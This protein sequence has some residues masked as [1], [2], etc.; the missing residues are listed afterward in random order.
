MSDDDRKFL[1]R[2]RSTFAET[3]FRPYVM[4]IGQTALAWNDLHEW[5][6]RLF[7]PFVKGPDRMNGFAIWQSQ[8]VDRSKRE[9]LRA[10]ASAATEQF[11][12]AWPRLIPDILWICKETEALEDTRNN[13]VHAPLQ[14]LLDVAKIPDEKSQRAF[15]A[16]SEVAPFDMGENFRAKRLVAKD[17]LLEFR[18]CRD[19]LLAL[20]N[21]TASVDTAW[22]KTLPWPDRPTLPTREDTRKGL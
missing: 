22:E 5:L 17:I 21:F 16:A 6:G 12:E 9:L 18:W 19:R 7:S 4:A 20:R 13:V 2:E 3:T 14:L 11:E 10:A 15:I 1:R 8:R